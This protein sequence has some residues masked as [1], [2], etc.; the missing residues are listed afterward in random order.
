MN[1]QR[2]VVTVSRE[3]VYLGAVNVSFSF[4]SDTDN[5]QSSKFL[6]LIQRYLLLTPLPYAL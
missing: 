2:S 4:V 6:Q 3:F 1:L 5:T